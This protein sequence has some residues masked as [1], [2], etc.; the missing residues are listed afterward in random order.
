MTSSLH[1]LELD[2][3]LVTGALLLSISIFFFSKRRR[4]S[5]PPGPRKLPLIGNLLDFPSEYDWLAYGR[6]ADKYG[7]IMSLSSFGSN[8]IVISNYATSAEIMEKKSPIYSSRPYIPMVD[9]LGW[10]DAM[11]S[12][13]YGLRFRKY[14]KVFHSEL[15][16]PEALK[17]Y[18]PQQE[19][20]AR[21]FLQQ[22]LKTPQRLME[23]CFQYVTRGLRCISLTFSKT[24]GIHNPPHCLR[25]H[26]QE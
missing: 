17:N 16:S 8:L 24:C 13:T 15:G 25:L 9:L 11:S 4:L 6:M 3:G 5:L 14:R 26:R 22:C 10:Q 21:N 1:G 7:P 12:Q 23:H 2:V 18:W 20:H 19:A